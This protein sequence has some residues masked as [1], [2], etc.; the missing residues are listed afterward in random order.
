MTKRVFSV[1]AFS[2]RRGSSQD[3]VQLDANS[4]EVSKKSMMSDR[5]GYLG[6]WLTMTIVVDLDKHNIEYMIK[7]TAWSKSSSIILTSGV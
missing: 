2:L 5:Y 6:V 4:S 1:K 3:L 7:N